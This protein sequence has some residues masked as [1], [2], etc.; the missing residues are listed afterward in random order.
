MFGIENLHRVTSSATISAHLVGSATPPIAGKCTS[1][2]PIGWT[3]DISRA[4]QDL[5]VLNE[6]GGVKELSFMLNHHRKYTVDRRKRF[7]KMNL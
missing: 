3:A 1:T 6:T 5:G 7:H 2:P 4:R